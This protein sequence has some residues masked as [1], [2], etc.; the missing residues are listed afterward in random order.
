ML[1]G[2]SNGR[3]S[4]C[5]KPRVRTASSLVRI[6]SALL[7][8]SRLLDDG[9]PSNRHAIRNAK[10][11]VAA[12][13][14][15]A[16]LERR[17]A[18]A[19]TAQSQLGQRIVQ[20]LRVEDLAAHAV[21]EAVR[22]GR[23]VEGQNQETARL[24]HAQRLLRRVLLVDDVLDHRHAQH[25]VEVRVLSGQLVERRELRANPL[26]RRPREKLPLDALIAGGVPQV[27]DIVEMNAMPA[28]REIRRERPAPSATVGDREI[29]AVRAEALLDAPLDVEIHPL[30]GRV[31][32]EAD[33]L[34]PRVRGDR[35]RL[36]THRRRVFA[37]HGFPQFFL[38]EHE[39]ERAVRVHV[40]END[41]NTLESQRCAY[42]P[43]VLVMPHGARSAAGGMSP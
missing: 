8:P 39:L 15:E 1:P 29:A 34:A 6:A 10:H 28:R 14:P 43:P 32:V 40:R 19:G 23:V 33:V 13:I 18:K 38:V 20:A 7:A 4:C 25:H 17:L 41:M 36:G 3:S 35:H 9:D 31:N 5:T 30:P 21:L 27:V 22:S 37:G 2:R 42:I 12:D 26:A 24:E 11:A 16:A